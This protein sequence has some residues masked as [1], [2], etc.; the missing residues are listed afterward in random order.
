M[1]ETA[2]PSASASRSTGPTDKPNMGAMDQVQ[3]TVGQVV[4]Q[5]QSAAGQVSEQAKQQASSQ[6]ESQ[7]GRAVDSLVTVA[8]ALRQTGQH[9]QQQDQSAVAGYVEQ[10]AER[11]ETVTNYLR[12]RD[13]PQLMADTQDFARRQ[14]A[15]FLT[16]AIALGFLGGRF[17]MSS[18]RR[19]A[20]QQSTS[21]ARAYTPTYG[22]T[23]LGP[24]G[25]TGFA[26]GARM[27]QSTA[28]IAGG[29]VPPTT[30]S[31]SAELRGAAGIRGGGTVPDALEA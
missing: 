12:G 27:G 2:S 20:P 5:A 9:L 26:A 30:G 1:S 10:A 18:G 31:P 21:L 8:Q 16:G 15:L 29:S 7:K 13:V 3:G 24:S 22:Y 19:A 14:P 17:L 28:P 23:E 11:V 4:D 25:S 6:L